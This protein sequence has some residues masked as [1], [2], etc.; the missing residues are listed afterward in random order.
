MSARIKPTDKV[1]RRR[2]SGAVTPAKHTSAS[3]KLA[4]MKFFLVRPND[5]MK[6]VR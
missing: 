5:L 6:S 3:D 2:Q 1:Q 4:R